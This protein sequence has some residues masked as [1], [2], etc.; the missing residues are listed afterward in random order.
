M[1]S[2]L[3]AL[4]LTLSLTANAY[5]DPVTGSAI[6]QGLVAGLAFVIVFFKKVKLFIQDIINKIF[7]RK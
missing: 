1:K 4:L 7:N 6:I 2:L 5:I 3:L